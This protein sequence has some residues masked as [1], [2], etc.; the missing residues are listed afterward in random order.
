MG[1]LA[2]SLRDMISQMKAHDE[3]MLK[4]INQHV[5]DLHLQIEAMKQ[6]DSEIDSIDKIVS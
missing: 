1:I 2:D 4:R 5:D 3:K 6:L